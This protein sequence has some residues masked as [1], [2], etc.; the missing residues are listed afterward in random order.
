MR[1]S[2]TVHPRPKIITLGT[3]KQLLKVG[4]LQLYKAIAAK[5][6]KECKEAVKFF[7]FRA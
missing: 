7:N 3:R 5:K 2:R 1:M 6:P 4:S